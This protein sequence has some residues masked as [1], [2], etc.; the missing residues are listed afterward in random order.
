MTTEKKATPGP[1][2]LTMPGLPAIGDQLIIKLIILDLLP[3]KWHYAFQK[4]RMFL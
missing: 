4:F 1:L 3:P 2:D